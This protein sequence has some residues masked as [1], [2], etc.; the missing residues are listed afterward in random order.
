[1]RHG[2]FS[3]ILFFENEGLSGPK[4]RRKMCENLSIRPHTM[5]SAL[6]YRDP[7]LRMYELFFW[8]FFLIL[9]FLPIVCE[10]H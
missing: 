5:T 2:N 8:C 1:M 10:T 9:P 6:S 4:N 7:P 3:A